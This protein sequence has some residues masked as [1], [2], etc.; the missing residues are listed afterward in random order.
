MAFIAVD[1]P[2]R[3]LTQRAAVAYVVRISKRCRNPKLEIRMA[4][5]TA[6][7]AGLFGATPA[8]LR[9]GNGPDQGRGQLVAVASHGSRTI[10]D[11]KTP[12]ACRHFSC[13]Y[14]GTIADAFPLVTKMTALNMEGA[15]SIENGIV[16]MLP[17]PMPK[18][19]PAA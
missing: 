16:F 12:T 15:P 18:E 13:P 3:T 11:G 6:S 8:S 9:L 17:K 4:A 7:K 2:K 14:V 19:E 10:T 1:P 5:A